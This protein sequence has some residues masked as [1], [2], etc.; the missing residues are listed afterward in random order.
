MSCFRRLLHPLRAS[1]GH[2]LTPTLMMVRYKH[3][4]VGANLAGELEES[5]D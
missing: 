4:T 1:D 2:A 3:D 5:E